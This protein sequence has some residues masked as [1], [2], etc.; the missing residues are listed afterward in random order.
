MQEEVVKLENEFARA[1]ASND[2]DTLDV[3]LADD[4]IIV[5]PDGSFIDKSRFL[6]VINPVFCPMS[7]WSPQ[8]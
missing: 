6:G 1:I 8:T 2:A 7:R 3:I 4:W 5:D